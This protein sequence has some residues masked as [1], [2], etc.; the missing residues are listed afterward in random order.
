MF[1]LRIL[2]AAT[3]V[4]ALAVN[5]LWIGSV[6]FVLFKLAKLALSLA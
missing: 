6:G 4:C 3:I 1:S 2:P 5:A